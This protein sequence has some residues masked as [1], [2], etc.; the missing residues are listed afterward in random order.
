MFDWMSRL[1]VPAF[2]SFA[3][4]AAAILLAA[5]VPP[6]LISTIVLVPL[7]I[8]AAILERVAPQRT[9]FVALDRPMRNEVA[10]FFV[11]YQF[12]SALAVA[13]CGAL[14][15]FV[16]IPSLWPIDWPM[17]AQLL[18]AGFLAE[19][20][21]YWQHRFF[22]HSRTLWRFHAL[23]HSG[24]RLNV[25]RTGRFH[26]VDIGAGT[27]LAF[28]PFVVV[29]APLAIVAWTATI[30]AALGILQH[31][32]IRATTPAWLDR[33][34]CTP[35]VHRTHHSRDARESDG[36]FGTWVMAFDVLFGTYVTPR[37]SGPVA[38]GIEGEPVPP[39]FWRELWP[40]T[41]RWI[42]ARKMR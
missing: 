10:H 11:N 1:V 41:S 19:C 21:S 32:N 13:A 23:H 8:A 30:A 15:G 9:D 12:G 7:V 40:S 29:G 18:L 22:H 6:M 17:P 34:I 27:F 39:G 38:A 25:V 20:L 33:L 35:A 4:A 26:F 31:A 24:S 36:N 5:G 16:N 2:V 28:A 14:A 3:A 42:S 37:A